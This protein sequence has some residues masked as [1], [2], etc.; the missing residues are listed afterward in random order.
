MEFLIIG[1][2]PV[3]VSTT[4]YAERTTHQLEPIRNIFA[5]LFLASIGLIMNPLFLWTHIDILFASLLVVVVA[6]VR[7][8]S[9]FHLCVRSGPVHVLV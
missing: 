4:E 9:P 5:A 2:V 7:A 6:K 3:K 1:P 8:D